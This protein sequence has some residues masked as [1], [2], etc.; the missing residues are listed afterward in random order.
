[1]ADDDVARFERVARPLLQLIQRLT[2]LETSFV[3]EIDWAAQRQEVLLALNTGDL[4]MAEGA[5]LPWADSMCRWSFLSDSPHTSDVPTDYPGSLG[6]E[7]LGLRTFVALPIQ[8]GDTVLGTVCGASRRAVDLDADVLASLELISDALAFQLGTLVKA[9][10]LQRRAEEA[11]ALALVDPLTGLANRRGFDARFEEELARSSR[12]GEPVAL[13]ALDLDDFKGVN[14]T[15]GHGA[16]DQILA[17]VGDV[18]RRAARA[19]DVVARLGGDEFVVLLTPGDA[20]VAEGVAARIAE[21]FRAECERLEIPCTL[22][23]G[24]ST[25]DTTP[26]RSL[27]VAADKALY[28][29]KAIGR[30]AMPSPSVPP[31]ARSHLSARRPPARPDAGRDERAVDAQLALGRDKATDLANT[32]AAFRTDAD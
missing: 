15:Y 26:R 11:E 19:E 9:Q 4:E 2:G 20:A 1:M 29:A 27:L 17:T 6:A 21:E 31:R 30:R 16:G 32:V 22:S 18:L 23:V 13:L 14:D 8:E 24:I 7:Q 3:T 12:R 28:R 5:T 10:Q 25:T